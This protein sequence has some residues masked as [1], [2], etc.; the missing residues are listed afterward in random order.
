[1]KKIKDLQKVLVLLGGTSVATWFYIEW[2]F[3]VMESGG[4]FETGAMITF[5]FI[6]GMFAARVFSYCL[7]L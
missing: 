3:I 1:M 5:G 6:L 4:L 2:F 7:D